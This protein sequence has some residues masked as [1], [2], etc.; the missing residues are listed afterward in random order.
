[1]DS[2]TEFVEEHNDFVVSEEA[3]LGGGWFGEGGEKGCCWI[4]TSTIFFL[5]TL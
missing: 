4:I 3:G 2:M 1:M 5:E